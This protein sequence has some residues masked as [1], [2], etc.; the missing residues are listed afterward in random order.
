MIR[1]NGKV[2]VYNK[3]PKNCSLKELLGALKD[4]NKKMYDYMN[5]GNINDAMTI[6][7]DNV[8][9]IQRIKQEV[10]KLLEKE[11][12]TS[13]GSVILPTPTPS[14][15]PA[16]VPGPL[17]HTHPHPRQHQHRQQQ[18][19]QQQYQGQF[20]SYPSNPSKPSR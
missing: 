9:V 8:I 1:N 6:N 18:P 3:D 19:P 5:I 4:T 2:L 14:T 15:T 13:T 12:T 17:I 7:E 16:T 20:P 11:N 10:Y